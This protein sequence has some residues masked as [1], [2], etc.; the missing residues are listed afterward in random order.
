MNSDK[1]RI[2]G[3]ITYEKD[4]DDVIE[5]LGEVFGIGKPT[6]YSLIPF[7]F[8]DCNVIVEAGGKKYVAKMFSKERDQAT[9]DRLVTIMT[10]VAEA[11]VQHPRLIESTTGG[12]L[13]QEGTLSMVLME[14]IQG[15]TFFELGRAPNSDELAS[16]IEQAVKINQIDYHPTALYDSWAV[17]YIKEMFAKVRG[18]L[19]AEDL[20]LV[21]EVMAQFEKISF[22]ELPRCFVHGDF[23]KANVMKGDNGKIYILDFSVANWYPRIQEIAVVSANLLYSKNGDQSLQKRVDSC[24]RLYQRWNPLTR[25]EK[26]SLFVY[27]LAAVAMEFM[28]SHAERYVKANMSPEV[29]YWMDLGRMQL[30]NEVLV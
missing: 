16:I 28:G 3:R 30:R 4:F 7:G 22:A 12:F 17:P 1:T 5:R 27:T 9:V 21:E 6:T 10:K 29:D 24:S 14:W 2:L 20:L 11:G 18:F 26:S 15:N 13:H 8:E 23:T 19:G 25:L